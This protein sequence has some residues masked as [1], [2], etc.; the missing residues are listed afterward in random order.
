MKTKLAQAERIVV[1]RAMQRYLHLV[2]EAGRQIA[3]RATREELLQAAR[4][5]VTDG[6]Y[7]WSVVAHIADQM[8][9]IDEL[10]MALLRMGQPL[11]KLIAPLMEQL[12]FEHLDL[13]DI[14]ALMAEVQAVSASP[15]TTISANTH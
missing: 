14:E 13:A 10:G 5:L 6:N 12:V 8:R 4:S 7:D 2:A 11:E 9:E 15:P 3:E 1:E